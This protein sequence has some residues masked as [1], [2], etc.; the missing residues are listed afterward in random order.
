LPGHFEVSVRTIERDLSALGQAGVPLAT[1]QGRTGGYMLD[2]SMSRGLVDGWTPGRHARLRVPLRR[3]APSRMAGGSSSRGAGIDAGCSDRLSGTAVPLVGDRFMLIG[4]Q[5]AP[6]GDALAL[7]T[8]AP[9]RG[10]RFISRDLTTIR[11]SHRPGVGGVDALTTCGFVPPGNIQCY[12][13]SKTL[14]SL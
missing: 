8:V 2:R 4:V 10:T 7:A 5:V 11:G 1:K 9:R 12:A 14:M 13:P 3:R 6:V